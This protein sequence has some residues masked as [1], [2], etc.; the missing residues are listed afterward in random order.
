MTE[1]REL[2]ALT[3][4]KGGGEMQPKEVIATNQQIRE[5]MRQLNEDLKELERLY[6]KEKSKRKARAVLCVVLCSLLFPSSTHNRMLQH[7]LTERCAC[8]VQ[9]KLNPEEMEMRGNMVTQMQNEV[10]ELKELALSG[11]VRGIQ[12][13]RIG[14]V[15]MEESEAFKGPLAGGSGGVPSSHYAHKAIHSCTF[16]N[17]P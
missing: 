7:G 9:S 5:H 17:R 16:G 4:N 1:V 11:Y 15:G 3:K 2:H 12:G 14:L 6:L 13:N 8:A 10:Q